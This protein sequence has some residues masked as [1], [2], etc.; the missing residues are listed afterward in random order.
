MLKWTNE[1]N[2]LIAET[3]KFKYSEKMA[4]FDFDGTLA[5]TK[6]KS[7]FALDYTDWIFFNDKV[8]EKLKLLIKNNYCLIIITN[9]AGLKNDILIKDWMKKLDSFEKSLKLEFKL[10]TSLDKDKFRKPQKGFFNLITEESKL[11]I[12]LDE[13]FYCGDALGRE[14]DHSDTDLKFALNCKLKC[15]SPEQVFNDDKKDYEYKL[16]YPDLKTKYCE[17]PKIKFDKKIMIILVGFPA[18]GKSYVVKE[19]SKLHDDNFTIVNRDTEKTMSKCESKT[20]STCENKLPI[21]IDNTNLSL[22]ERKKFIEIGKKY[23]Y[24]IFC[25]HVTTPIDVCEHNNYFRN[26]K[27]NCELVPTIAYR[28]MNKRYVEPT[29]EEGFYKIIKYRPEII[30]QDYELYYF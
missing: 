13:S 12:N 19:L 24:K 4:I 14:N 10:F 20:K 17:L 18:S 16:T 28:A 15:K 27:Y 23:Q 29:L 9:Q 30:N 7:K 5:V 1:K 6:S 26:Y 21:I 2:Y 3:G 11:E 22:E 25:V 8:I